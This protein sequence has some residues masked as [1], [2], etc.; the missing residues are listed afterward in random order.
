MLG[1]GYIGLA[2]GMLRVHRNPIGQRIFI[3]M[4]IVMASFAFAAFAIQLLTAPYHPIAVWVCVWVVSL[5]LL[6]YGRRRAR[7]IL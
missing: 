3:T 4:L 2:I 5:T 6:L 7:D 1:G